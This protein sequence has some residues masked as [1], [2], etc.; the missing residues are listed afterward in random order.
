[1]DWNPDYL[2]RIRGSW[3][4]RGRDEIIVFTLPNAMPAALMETIDEE[5]EE[6]RRR[7][8]SMCPEEW[9]ES[10]GDEFY[11]YA[12]DNSFFFL[13]PKQIGLIMGIMNLL[14]EALLESISTLQT[15]RSTCKS[16]I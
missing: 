9:N 8:V 13:A 15:S 7:R 6:M 16:L 4:A 2:Y 1:M 10:F 14:T 11:E 3:A 12:L 5:S